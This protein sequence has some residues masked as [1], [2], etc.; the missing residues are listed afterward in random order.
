[1]IIMMRLTLHI[2]PHSQTDVSLMVWSDENLSQVHRN[3]SEIINKYEA[4]I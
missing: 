2:S 1:M 3:I 4:I